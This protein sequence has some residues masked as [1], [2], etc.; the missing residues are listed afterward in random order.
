GDGQ[1]VTAA[2]AAIKVDATAAGYG[3]FVDPSPTDDSE[4]EVA[5]PNKERQATEYN[6]AFGKIDLLT[7]VMRAL[8]YIYLQG[9]STIPD[10]LKQLLDNTLSPGRRRRCR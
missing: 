8:G 10:R 7:V 6:P 9:K 3:W 2:S 1:L 4:F 5:V